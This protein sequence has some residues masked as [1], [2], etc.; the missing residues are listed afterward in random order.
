M[1]TENYLTMPLSYKLQKVLRYTKLYGPSRTIAKVRSQ[2]HMAAEDDF[3]GS[4]WDNPKCTSRDSPHR[5]IGI[6]GCGSFAFGNVAYYLEKTYPGSL[7]GVMDIDPA[8]A[9]SFASHYCAAFATTEASEIMDDPLISLVYVASNHA[10]H[11]P[12]AI[13]AL[14]SGK[15]VHIE[16][17]HVVTRVES[18]LLAEAMRR[19]PGQLVFLG[20]NRPR[21]TL[22]AR[23][24]RELAREHG[25]SMI[26]WFVAGHEIQDDHW[27]F[28]EEEGGRIL[29]NLCHWTDLTLEIVGQENAFPCRVVPVSAP[30][31]KSDFVTSFEFADGSL[32]TITFSAKGHTFEGVRETLN[33]HKGNLLA[34]IKDF[35][36]LSIV[37]GTERKRIRTLFRDHGHQSNII[38]SYAGAVLGE[39]KRAPGGQSICATADLFLAVREAHEKNAA[40]KVAAPNAA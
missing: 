35:G 11:A 5:A 1:A 9:R 18:Q 22:F 20:F 3:P 31:A 2:L 39:D 6:V 25:P 32:A 16:K 4:R 30:H 19:N 26:N 23:L 24:M 13:Q 10:S 15:H 14:D 34:E 40:V 36:S 28:S 12:Y 37:R 17:P 38:N 21:S 33:L 29:G 27:Y 8:R 7:K